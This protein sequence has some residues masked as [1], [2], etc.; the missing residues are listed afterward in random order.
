MLDPS[1]ILGVIFKDDLTDDEHIEAL[2]R[3][4]CVRSNTLIRNF[5]M[6]DR[7]AKVNLF[8]S[9]CTSLYGIPLALNCKKDSMRKLRVSYIDSLRYLMNNDRYES[10]SQQFVNFRIPSFEELIRK[11]YLKFIYAAE[12]LGK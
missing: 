10:I 8:K 2:Y 4:Q 7:N 3:G 1:N 9:F 6:C 11:K 12:A 5:Y